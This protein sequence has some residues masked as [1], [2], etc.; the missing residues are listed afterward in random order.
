MV[1]GKKKAGFNNGLF[2]PYYEYKLYY[3]R[4]ILDHTL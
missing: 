4:G 3:F 1:L 2:V